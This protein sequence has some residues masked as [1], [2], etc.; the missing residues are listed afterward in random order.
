VPAVGTQWQLTAETCGMRTQQARCCFKHHRA[1][2]PVPVLAP[3]FLTTT[4]PPPS[5]CAWSSPA[6]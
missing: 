5:S 2:F 1:P 6:A 4:R 3:G